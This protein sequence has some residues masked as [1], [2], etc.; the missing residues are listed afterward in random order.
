M[1]PDV[2]IRDDG[3]LLVANG[4]VSESNNRCLSQVDRFALLACVDNGLGPITSCRRYML[5]LWED[6][7]ECADMEEPAV[8]APQAA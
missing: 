5:N 6:I 8:E 4:R 2:D 1:H 7:L 3:L